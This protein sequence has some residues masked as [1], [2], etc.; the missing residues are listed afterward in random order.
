MWLGQLSLSP[1]SFFSSSTV[2]L[3][4]SVYDL[5]P[6]ELQLPPCIEQ[7]ITTMSQ[8]SG[9]GTSSPPTT[10]ASGKVLQPVFLS[11]SFPVYYHDINVCTELRS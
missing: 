7:T 4:E 6:K 5:L 3:P 8:N 11:P 1:V 9:G 10:L 2:S